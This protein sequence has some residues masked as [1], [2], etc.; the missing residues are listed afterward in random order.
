[1]S[2]FNKMFNS[3]PTQNQPN[4]TGFNFNPNPTK[5]QPNNTGFNFNPN[6]TENQPNNTGFNFNPNP[7]KKE[8][9]IEQN[10]I[11]QLQ[12]KII[13]LDNKIINLEKNINITH[14]CSEVIHTNINCDNCKK[15]NITGIRH[16]C[17]SCSD[18][19]L[20]DYCINFSNM[21]HPSNHYFIRIIDTEK[22]NN[23]IRDNNKTL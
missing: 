21:I 12:D 7:T 17:Y 13:E 22:F 2:N 14:K 18:Y 5:N 1:M 11:T 3:N 8:N 19:D 4:N 23:D 10:A 9:I 20:C 6:P 15:N 16:K